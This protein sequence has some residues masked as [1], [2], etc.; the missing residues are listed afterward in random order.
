[1]G[2]VNSA[3]DVVPLY[4]SRS[5][6]ILVMGRLRL[7]LALAVVAPVAVVRGQA[8]LAG[9]VLA[10]DNS[11]PVAGAVI[12]AAW[13]E[14]RADKHRGVSQ[15]QV[16]HDTVSDAAGH[17]RICMTPGSSAL[18]QVRLGQSNS[19]YP[20]MS[21]GRDSQAVDL[22]I[23]THD[24][25][26][27]ANVSGTVVSEAGAPVPRANITV[28]G[29]SATT[30]TKDDGTYDMRDLPP[31]SQILIARSIG[32]GAA[33]VAVDLSPHA[34]TTVAVK[35]QHLPPMLDVVNVVADRLQLANV[36][37]DIGFTKR[38]RQGNGIFM[39]ADQIQARQPFDTPELFRGVPGVRVMDNHNGEY[40][41]YSDRGPTTINDYG[42]CTAYVVDG[43]LIGNGKANTPVI[44]GTI[45]PYGGPDELMLPPPE[46]LIA[47]EIYQ[48]NEP[49]PYVL[50]GE[51]ARCL[52]I[53]LWTKAQLAGK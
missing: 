46:E 35:M 4:P 13:T 48:P 3:D 30:R 14:L 21:A 52:K 29:S 37:R 33:V 36:Y 5:Q 10:A 15:V 49:S 32:L 50:S 11:K 47:V 41:V 18:I 39:N 20:V 23:T 7:W 44:P 45:I 27:G 28:L 26:D 38:Q 12:S 16:A 8:C 51:A 42:D 53:L 43:T 31:G 19:Y 17:Y 2:F 22:R 34:T 1:M 9:R 6:Y 25:S 24:E 40:Q